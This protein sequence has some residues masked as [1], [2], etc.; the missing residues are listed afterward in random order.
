MKLR[1]VPDGDL[2]RLAALAGNSSVVIRSVFIAVVCGGVVGAA[3]A[4][5]LPLPGA[6]SRRPRTPLSP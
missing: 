6:V 1:E 3:A 2:V 4:D 5:R